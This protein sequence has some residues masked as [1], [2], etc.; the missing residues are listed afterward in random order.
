MEIHEC[1]NNATSNSTD[2]YYKFTAA[3]YGVIGILHSIAILVIAINYFIDRKEWNERDIKYWKWLPWLLLVILIILSVAI[4]AIGLAFD[5]QLDHCFT[6]WYHLPTVC[7]YHCMVIVTNLVISIVL[8]RLVYAT[9]CVYYIWKPIRAPEENEGKRGSKV[10]RKG[11]SD[12]KP[13]TG[14]SKT[15]PRPKEVGDSKPKETDP[16]TVPRPKEV[17]DSQPKETDS[18]TVPRPIEVSDSKPKETD[19]ET[20]PRPKEVGDFKPVPVRMYC[21][22]CKDYLELK[23]RASLSYSEICYKYRNKGKEVIPFTSTF[24]SWFVLQ[25]FIYFLGIFIDLTFVVRPWILGGNV[26][27][28]VEIYKQH[29]LEYAYIS[30]FIVYDITVF[31]IPFVCG[32]KMNKYHDGYY[33]KLVKAKENNFDFLADDNQKGNGAL[34]YALNATVLKVQKVQEFDFTPTISGIDIPLTN[35]GYILSIVIAMVALILG[36]LVNPLDQKN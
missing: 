21:G 6:R 36:F 32:I 29:P 4:T 26:H 1:H 25:W 35:P 33:S 34:E 28:S 11:K 10:G 5:L 14:D 22:Y 9:V 2:V 8:H 27:D 12:A 3:L 17:G 24:Q 16:E 13:A 15:V 30:M 20:V 31:I 18:E 19:S 7:I 23:T